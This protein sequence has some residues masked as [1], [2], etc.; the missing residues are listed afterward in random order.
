M[1]YIDDV[2]PV[3]NAWPLYQSAIN[4]SADTRLLI[5]GD[6]KCSPEATGA[7]LSHGITR[8]WNVGAW[9]FMAP[10]ARYLGGA[11]WLSF[12][13]QPASYSAGRINRDPGAVY[14]G[15]ES[16][17]L[18]CNGMDYPFSGDVPAASASPFTQCVLTDTPNYA[19]VS[20]PFSSVQMT[21]RLTYYNNPTNSLQSCRVRSYRNAGTDATPSYTTVNTTTLTLN[22]GTAGMTYLDVDCGTGA[23]APG[24]GIVENS[25]VETGLNLYLGPPVFYRG[26]PGVRT[27]GFGISH[28]ANGGHKP[29]DVLAA[30]GGGASPTC[31]AANARWYLQNVGFTPNFVLLDIG[32]NLNAGAESNELNAGTSTTYRANINAILDQINTLYAG[33]SG[34]TAPFVIIVNPTRSGYTDLHCET[35]GRCLFSI[36][37][38]RNCG[39]LDMI[40]L[41]PYNTTG[42]GWWTE[43]DIHYSGPAVPVHTI[44]GNGSEA[45]AASMWGA[46]AGEYRGRLLTS[47]VRSRVR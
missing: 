1:A 37:Q 8:T 47:A 3:W 11:G 26:T 39:F 30:L 6:S 45:V 10:R 27:T 18:P 20:A 28:I 12:G 36:A 46:M 2:P 41:M 22:T 35:K 4:S 29:E 5:V 31:T 17:F 42:T 44:T 23:N 34:A 16:Q 33:I 25:V 9:S 7:P 21:S 14:T 43:D 38:Q 19:R 15:G 32:Q 13:F 24:V 40:Q